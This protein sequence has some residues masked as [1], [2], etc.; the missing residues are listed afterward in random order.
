MSNENN[1]KPEYEFLALTVFLAENLGI[2]ET[3]DLLNK[4]GITADKVNEAIPDDWVNSVGDDEFVEVIMS[5][6]ER[7]FAEIVEN[8]GLIYE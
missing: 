5:R 8:K 7:L 1:L 2:D 4:V 3:R 6:I